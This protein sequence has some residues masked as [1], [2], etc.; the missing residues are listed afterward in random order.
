MR[1]GGAPQRLAQR[2]PPGLE[3]GAAQ[4]REGQGGPRVPGVSLEGVKRLGRLL[5]QPRVAQQVLHQRGGVEPVQD[6]EELPAQRAR[7]RPERA[8]LQQIGL[9]PGPDREQP[10]DVGGGGQPDLQLGP[11]G[12]PGRPVEQQRAEEQRLGLPYGNVGGQPVER[13]RGV[14]QQ[15]L[16]VVAVGGGGRCTACEQ[17]PQGLGGVGGEVAAEGEQ[18]QRTGGGLL[19]RFGDGRGGRRPQERVRGVESAV[20]ERTAGVVAAV[21]AA[22]AH[23]VGAGRDGMHAARRPAQHAGLRRPLE[24]QRGHPVHVQS[25]GVV[26]DGGREGAEQRHVRAVRAQF[27]VEVT[28]QPFAGLREPGRS[29]PGERG[30]QLGGRDEAAVQKLG[31]QGDQALG[32]GGVAGAGPGLVDVDRTETAEQD[33]RHHRQKGISRG[34]GR[35]GGDGE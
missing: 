12:L 33:G 23:E 3:G 9:T 10:Q 21:P 2:V 5:P 24:Q 32:G 16:Q 13:G 15:H 19:V 35:G 7:Q 11:H 28:E 31:L 17:G 6:A 29:E 34:R 25:E 4:D 27:G 30:A 26:R 1:G 22:A 20:A 8:G 14:G 18:P